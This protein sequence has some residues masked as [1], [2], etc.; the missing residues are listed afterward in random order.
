MAASLVGMMTTLLGCSL[1]AFADGPLPIGDVISAA[2][3]SVAGMTIFPTLGAWLGLEVGTLTVSAVATQL[4]TLLSSGTTLMALANNFVND[5]DMEGYRAET[6]TILNTGDKIYEL[7]GGLFDMANG[8]DGSDEIGL[9]FDEAKSADVV[10]SNIT[11]ILG[12][13]E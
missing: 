3:T 13:D 9:R 10:S 2:C 6:S 1:P 12:K 7:R 5:V 11:A 8:W 4:Y